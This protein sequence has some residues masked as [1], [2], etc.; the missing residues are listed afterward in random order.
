MSE[1]IETRPKSELP[2]G[3]SKSPDHNQ[4]QDLDLTRDQVQDQHPHQHKH[5]DQDAK[6][7]NT[8]PTTP[9]TPPM[10]TESE[11]TASQPELFDAEEVQSKPVTSKKPDQ[12][13]SEEKKPESNQTTEKPSPGPENQKSDSQKKFDKKPRHKN[14]GH[15]K[16]GPKKKNT[17]NDH[18]KK[19]GDSPKEKGKNEGGQGQH[20]GQAD[21][22]PKKSRKERY[23]ER[24]EK[25]RARE[26]AI[27]EAAT[28]VESEGIVEISPKGFGFLREKG[29]GF[30]QSP[31]DVF[32][33]PEIVR[34]NGLRDGLWIKCI[35]K[36]GVRG[37]QLIEMLE[38]NGKKP[39]AYLNLPYFE[40]LTAI[41]PDKR[42]TLET[43]ATRTTTRVIDLIAPIGRGQRGLIVA[44]PRTG[45]TTLLQHMAEAIQKN[46][47]DMHLIV[48]LVDE[49]PEEVTDFERSFPDAEVLSS[50]NDGDVK[51][52]TRIALLAIERA[53]RL[54]EAGE[55]VF[56]FNGFD[57]SPGPC[58]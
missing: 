8:P 23:R 57:H 46:Y 44:P 43:S 16:N 39:E 55:H 19:E 31:K 18:R 17:R 49:R 11:T 47:E 25:E 51:D 3:K 35:S 6:P 58:F 53:K 9:N 34:V 41:N 24:K 28:P 27:L 37:P 45:K 36:E 48:L 14:K 2:P 32:I 5:Q 56:Y 54:V 38:I 50:S 30:N 26:A 13:D 20:Q 4:G 40:E 22:P 42:L 21:G 1:E 12:P 29:R 33:T 52:H 10:D 7:Q 15:G